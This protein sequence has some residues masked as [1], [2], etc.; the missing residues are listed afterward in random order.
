MNQHCDELSGMIIGAALRVHESLGPGFLECFYEDALCVELNTV[1]VSV[2]RQIAV[3]VRYRDRLIGEHRLD[4]L[5]HDEIVVELKAVA[6][7]DPIHFAVL[8]SYLKAANRSLGLLLNFAGPTLQIKRVGRGWHSR[9][10]IAGW[11]S[12]ARKP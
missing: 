9:H 2:A 8:R 4:L 1:G 10:G 6:G 7:F 12:E 5:V 3:P 11:D